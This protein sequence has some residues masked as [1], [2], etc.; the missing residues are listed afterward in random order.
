MGETVKDIC[1]RAHSALKQTGN[2]VS[3]SMVAQPRGHPVEWD[4]P[5]IETSMTSQVQYEKRMAARLGVGVEQREKE[6]AG[7][8][9]LGA[10]CRMW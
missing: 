7:G 9:G 3:C 1:N 10:L 6:R 8:A 5:G 2:A 4:N